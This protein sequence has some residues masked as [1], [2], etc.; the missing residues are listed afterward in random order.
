MTV[1]RGSRTIELRPINSVKVMPLRFLVVVVLMSLAAGRA[2]VVSAQSLADLAKKEEERRK[3][4]K[5]PTKVITNKDLAPVPN[6]TTPAPADGAAVPATPASGGAAKDAKGAKD[7]KDAKDEKDAKANEPGK[8]K[9][10]WAGR[11]KGLQETLDRDQTY[12]DALQS[13]INA[14][15]TDFVNRA[16]PAQR[17]VIERDRQRSLAELAKLKEQIQKDKKAL[18]DLDEEARRAGVPPG[19]LR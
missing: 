19:W 4:M 15:T 6:G 16:D 12:A 10:Y 9:A 5:G 2:A 11:L 1:L 18:A 3:E 8:D 17:S 14:L 13:R 7:A